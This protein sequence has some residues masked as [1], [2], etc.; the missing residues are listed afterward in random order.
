M[1]CF[2][3]AARYLKPQVEG[4]GAAAKVQLDFSSLLAAVH[5]DNASFQAF[6]RLFVYNN[7]FILI[8]MNHRSPDFRAK[9]IWHYKVP[10]VILN[11]RNVTLNYRM[12]S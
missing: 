6:E 3:Y 10:N 5:F 7:A 4:V 9:V 1:N 12:S 2:S 11:H 8:K